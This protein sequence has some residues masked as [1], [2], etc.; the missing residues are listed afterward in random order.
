MLSCVLVSDIGIYN[1]AVLDSL[2]S[3][4]KSILTGNLSVLEELGYKFSE[5]L[6]KRQIIV[7]K[8]VDVSADAAVVTA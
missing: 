2:L 8:S 1:S 7:G 4:K 6:T 5:N 3:L